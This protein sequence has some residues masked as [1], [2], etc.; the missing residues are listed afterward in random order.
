MDCILKMV[1]SKTSQEGI[2]LHKLFQGK[3]EILSHADILGPFFPHPL[4]FI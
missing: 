2:I 1:Y 3:I 4:S